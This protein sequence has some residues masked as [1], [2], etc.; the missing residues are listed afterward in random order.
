MSHHTHQTHTPDTHTHTHQTHTHTPDTHTRQTHTHARHTH[1][2]LTHTLH[3]IP[4]VLLVHWVEQVWCI[5]NAFSGGR[6]QYNARGTN[7]AGETEAGKGAGTPD[8][9]PIPPHPP[10]PHHHPSHL[11]HSSHLPLCPHSPSP[12][13][14]HPCRCF[15]PVWGR[16]WPQVV[17]ESVLLQRRLGTS[18]YLC[19]QLCK[20]RIWRVPQRVR[21][22]QEGV[23]R[24]GHTHKGEGKAPI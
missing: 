16:R 23:G 8:T 24:H 15:P 7:V 3:V 14:S 6:E 17:T 11:T 22:W 5:C 19:R 13:H 20:C 1:A 21:S 9:P 18:T 4:Q 12:V 2:P 10:L